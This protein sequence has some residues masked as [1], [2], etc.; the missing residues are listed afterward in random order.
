MRRG[1][2]IVN[3]SSPVG[4]IGA[5][6]VS[7]A[8]SKAALHG[9]TM[10]CAQTLGPRSIWVNLV[11]PGATITRMTSDWSAEKRAAVAAE[12]FL[13]RLC[14]PREVATAVAFLLS[15]DASFITGATL[16]VT[17]GALRGR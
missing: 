8:A 16:D 5:R 7:Y 12:S 9:L 3:V 4:L 13:G 6:K 2:S 17:G 14:E 1:G 15:D 11:L 10:S